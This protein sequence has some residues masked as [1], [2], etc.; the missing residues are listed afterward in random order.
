MV[1]VILTIKPEMVVE[2]RLSKHAA[3]SILKFYEFDGLRED[4]SRNKWSPQ[5]RG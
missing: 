1:E 5:P 2:F 3:T 4:L